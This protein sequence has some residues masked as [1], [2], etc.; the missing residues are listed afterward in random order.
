MNQ[1]RDEYEKTR[2]GHETK[3]EKYELIIKYGL[4]W[5]QSSDHRRR[6]L[7]NFI[8]LQRDKDSQIQSANETIK[9]QKAQAEKALNELK[10]Q[11]EYNSNKLYDDMKEQV[12][13]TLNY[14]CYID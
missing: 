14:S 7:I 12:R 6:S 13:Q 1:M 8:W 3:I 10:K 5:N 11:V 9:Q 4:S 2:T